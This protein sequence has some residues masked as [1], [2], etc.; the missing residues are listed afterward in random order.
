[1]SLGHLKYILQ[2]IIKGKALVEVCFAFVLYISDS[3]LTL[4]I[5]ASLVIALLTEEV[6]LHAQSKCMNR[7]VNRVQ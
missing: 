2:G 4:P 1:M 7:I 3:E 6:A 5:I